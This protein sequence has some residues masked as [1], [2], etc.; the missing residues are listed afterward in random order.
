MTHVS[1]SRSEGALGFYS[2]TGSERMRIDSSGR[3]GINYTPVSQFD[4]KNASSS[5]YVIQC[6]SSAN[7]SLGGLFEDSSNNGELYVKAAGNVTNVLLNSSG[8]SYLKG[9]NVGINKS[10]EDFAQLE[11]KADTNG[12][13]ALLLD[14]NASTQDAYIQHG[15]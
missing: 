7:S 5:R 9:G 6:F 14:S 1:Q 3:V 4:V 8:D 13:A 15:S 12:K 2:S 10:P 11:V